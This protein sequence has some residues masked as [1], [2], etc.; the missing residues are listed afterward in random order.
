MRGHMSND[1]MND[2]HHKDLN[3]WMAS[4]IPVELHHEIASDDRVS[5]VIIDPVNLYTLQ[6]MAGAA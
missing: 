4:G 3:I 2:K 1:P 6:I 5:P